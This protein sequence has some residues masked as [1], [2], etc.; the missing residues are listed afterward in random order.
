MPHD[1]P[2]LAPLIGSAVPDDEQAACFEAREYYLEARERRLVDVRGVVDDKIDGPGTGPRAAQALANIRECA[3]EPDSAG[4]PNNNAYC[5]LWSDLA[6]QSG[7][8]RCQR[9]APAR[10]VATM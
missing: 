5:P 9:L 8:Y 6:G 3:T 10:N 2:L 4:S 1:D 7:T